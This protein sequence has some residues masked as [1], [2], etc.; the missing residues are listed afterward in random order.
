M[1]CE[2]S[3]QKELY[4]SVPQGSCAEPV[5]YLAYANTIKEIVPTSESIYDYADDHTL[6]NCFKSGDLR[7]ELKCIEA[8]D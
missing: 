1:G 5:L 3:S 8:I 2:Y 6:M 7:A 4:F